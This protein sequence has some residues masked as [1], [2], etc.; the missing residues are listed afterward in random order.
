LND[1][2][3]YQINEQDSGN[4]NNSRRKLKMNV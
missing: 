2:V 1:Q 4:N 3:W